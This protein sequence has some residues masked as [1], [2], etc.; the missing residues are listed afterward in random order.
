[1]KEAA[2]INSAIRFG[3]LWVLQIFVLQ[4]ISWG[5]GGKDVL[6]IFL[7]PLFILLLP[8]R[9]PRTAVIAL[10]FALGLA[11]DFAYE[12]LGMHAAA[13][14][15]TAYLRP[16]ILQFIQPREKYNIKAD[17]TVAHL[18]WGWFSRYAAYMLL[19]HFLF[20]FSVQAFSFVFWWDIL[21]KTFFSFLVSYPTLL[22][23]ML[24]LNPKS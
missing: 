2:L 18:G 10:S 8:L 19:A 24:V 6:F 7:Y 1:M 12:T 3:L 15:F 9:M 13:A 22:F 4:Q 14:T 11:I 16:A 20:F 21:L 23:T 5:F 17:P